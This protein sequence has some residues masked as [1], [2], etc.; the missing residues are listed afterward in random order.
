MDIIR[1]FYFDEIYKISG[2]LLVVNERFAFTP[3]FQ[4]RAAPTRFEHRLLRSIDP[5]GHVK[6]LNQVGYSDLLAGLSRQH[7]SLLW[8]SRTDVQEV[9]HNLGILNIWTIVDCL[10]AWPWF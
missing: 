9:S 1:W 8:L 5:H 3:S 2:I 4:P 6:R 7:D 10:V